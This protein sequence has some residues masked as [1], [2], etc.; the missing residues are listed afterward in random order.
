MIK[1]LTESFGSAFHQS[2]RIKCGAFALM[3]LTALAVHAQPA[4]DNFANA[5]VITG[6]S[7][8]IHGSNVGAT[9]QPGEPD[10]A[11][12]PD[13]PAASVWYQW[14][15]PINGGMAFSTEGSSFDTVMA[16]YTGTNISQLTLLAANDDVN[17]LRGDFTSQIGFPVTNGGVYYISVDG[18][19]GLTGSV[20]L[21]WSSFLPPAAPIVS[22]V[23]SSTLSVSW[24]PVIP[25]TNFNI[26]FWDLYVDSSTN[27]IQVNNI[28][29]ANTNN[30]NPNETHSFQVAY[31]LTDGAAS[32]PS[33]S[34]SGTTWGG[35]TNS[36]GLPDNWQSLYWGTNSTNWPS[37]GSR[38]GG[39][40]GPTTVLE[41]FQWGADPFVPANWLTMSITNSSNGCSLSWN[42]LPGYVYQ[43]Q[44]ST[45]LAAWTN[46]G[47]PQ[48]ATGTN[49]SSNVGSTNR[50]FYRINRLLF[51]GSGAYY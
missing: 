1:L 44:T 48:F 43:I 23:N 50:G 41:V 51:S 6:I 34:T 7:G 36:D 5:A 45:N 13:G 8:A 39:S 29:W 22:A 47:L 28:V 12:N 24:N 38:L 17:Y 20:Q 42:T 32:P 35:D 10:D 30:Y 40:A 21:N 31:V 2:G 4:N 49:H 46:L 16:A 3:A 33:A 27:P 25:Y 26:A 9:A 18:F 15:S 11:S 19:A 37:P 14:I